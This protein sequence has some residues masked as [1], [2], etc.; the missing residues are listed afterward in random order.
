MLHRQLHNALFTAAISAMIL[1]EAEA[2]TSVGNGPT[3]ASG[4]IKVAEKDYDAETGTFSIAFRNGVSAEVELDKLPANIVRVLAL[5]GLSQKLGDS[6]ASVK[7]DVDEA[8]K[9]FNSVLDQLTKGEWAKAR[10]AGE[11]GAKVT[12]LAQAIARFR[13]VPVDKATAAVGKAT[14]E[15]IAGW[16][17]HPKLKAII[18]AIRAEKAAERAK[19]AEEKAG[20]KTAT[21]ADLEAITFDDSD[22]PAQSS[23]ETI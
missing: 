3:S 1:Q 22:S 16:K 4:R 13:D 17:S 5:H 23:G 14:K 9:R 10:E 7:G 12:E 8:I 11:G 19:A 21:D 15:Q 20:E 6:Y 2:Q 18:A